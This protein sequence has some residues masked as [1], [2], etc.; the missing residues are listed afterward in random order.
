MNSSTKERTLPWINN[1]YKKGTISFSHKLQRPS[2]QW[3]PLAKSKLIHSLLIGIPVQYIFVVEEKGVTYILD[4]T[5]RTSTVISYINNEF[6][7]SKKLPP[8]TLKTVKD[9]EVVSEDFEIAGKKFEKLDEAVKQALLASSFTFCTISDYTDEEVTEMFIRWNSGKPLSN[10]HMR[11][12]YES[13]EFNAAINT[14]A[15]HPLLKKILTSTQHKN[16]TSRDLL[17]QTLMLL[18]SDKD[19]DFTSFRNEDMNSFIQ[20][21]S[22]KAMTKIETLE[23]ALSKLDEVFPEKVKIP[24]TSIPMIL[25]AGCQIYKTKKSFEAFAK[26][27]TEFLANYDKNAE[28]KASVKEGTLHSENVRTRFEYWDHIARSI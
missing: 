23:A 13:D 6:K 16:G 9:G 21:H 17:I 22:D 2:D 7:L 4:G 20:C 24:A 11:V 10:K 25:Y 1:Q 27:I 19:N 14:L 26:Q 15:D 18:C 28:Y 8:I 12:V 3:S 5:Q